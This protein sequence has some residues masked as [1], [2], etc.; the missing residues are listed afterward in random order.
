[1]KLLLVLLA[2]FLITTTLSAAAPKLDRIFPAGG[3]RGTTVETECHGDFSWPIQ[4]WA[5]G[6]EVEVTDTKGLLKV[7]IP[8]DIATDRVWIRL[9]DGEGVTDKVPFLIDSLFELQEAEPNNSLKQSQK[10]VEPSVLI[11]GTLEQNGDVDAF[12]MQVEE[13]QTLVAALDANTRLNSPM[14][15]ILQVVSPRGHV[16]AENHDA[17][18][19]DPRLAYTATESG[20]LVVRLFAFPAKPGTSIQLHGGADYLYRLTLT[21]G[22]YI[23]HADPMTVSL[24]NPGEVEVKGWNIPPRTKLPVARLGG[25]YL[26][27]APEYESSEDTRI[28]PQCR[29]GFAYTDHIAS[30]VRIRLAPYEINTSPEQVPDGSATILTMP[31]AI[32]GSISEPNEVDRYLIPVKQGDPLVIAVES[33]ALASPLVPL[34]RLKDAT[35]KVVSEILETGPEQDAVITHTAAE[36]GEYELTVTD[37]YRQGG[38][39]FDYRVTA[40]VEEAAF[41]LVPSTEKVTVSSGT[42]AKLEITIRRRSGRDETVGAIRIQATN[43]PPGVNCP[44][45]VSEPGE[46][47]ADKVSLEFSTSGVVQA[48]GPVLILGVAGDRQS[49]NLL[50][51]FVTTIVNAP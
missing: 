25:R 18:G 12:E 15:A 8:S 36:D 40:R 28:S 3:Q 2:P 41:E 21:T 17:I 1:M 35:G 38:D 14:D 6:V 49:S 5:P 9:Y 30:G 43:L 39:W 37:R 23:T 48:T 34:V 51:G 27:N 20:P 32:M 11:N 31:N 16:L 44:E 50:F 7:T 19:L 45:V 42:P 26:K 4:V 46:E 13:G 10:I 33:K 47:T 24:A 29:I 22:P